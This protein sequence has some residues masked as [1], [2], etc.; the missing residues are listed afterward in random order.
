MVTP[1]S[2]SEEG[3]QCVRNVQNW[4]NQF[5][6]LIHKPDCAPLVKL[7]TIVAYYEACERPSLSNR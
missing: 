5:I 4:E 3:K 6:G 2:S 7:V 1:P